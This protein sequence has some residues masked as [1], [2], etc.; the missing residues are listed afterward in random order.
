MLYVLSRDKTK[1]RK[2]KENNPNSVEIDDNDKND[3][4]H[5]ENDKNDKEK[6]KDQVEDGDW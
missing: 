6:D 5:P 4:Q 1:C 2:K 3:I